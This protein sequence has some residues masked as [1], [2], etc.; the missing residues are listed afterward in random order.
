VRQFVPFGVIATLLAI[1]TAGSPAAALPSEVTCSSARD[2]QVECPM[3]TRGVVRLARQL[4][5]SPC[6]E[7][8]TW[9]LHGNS[10][11]VKNGCRAVFVNAADQGVAPSSS[12]GASNRVKCESEDQRQVNCP[13][14][15]R[16][17]VKVEHQLSHA[18]CIQGQSWGLVRDAVW[19][20]DGCRAIFVNAAGPGGSWEGGSGQGSAPRISI[21]ACNRAARKGYDG[22]V[23]EQLARLNGYWEVVL[24]F[25]DDRYACIVSSGGEVASFYKIEYRVNCTT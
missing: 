21:E 22:A 24:R 5:K 14:N 15:T 16:G 7:G 11:W 8:Q 10:V 25:D 2:R 6:I 1:S 4:S 13:M 20:K 19:V 23:V 17:A 18:P 3:N 12:N 9:G